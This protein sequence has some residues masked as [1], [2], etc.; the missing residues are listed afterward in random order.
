MY[1]RLTAI[2][3]TMRSTYSPTLSEELIMPQSST[4]I[5]LLPIATLLTPAERL[6]VDAI[7]EGYY[8]TVHRENVTDL[9]RAQ[10]EGGLANQVGGTQHWL[11]I[12]KARQRSADPPSELNRV[13]GSLQNACDL[14]QHQ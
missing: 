14:I 2:I 6:R 5:D 4:P 7:G 10:G 1:C 13:T 9:I 12:L 8:R 3:A 11:S